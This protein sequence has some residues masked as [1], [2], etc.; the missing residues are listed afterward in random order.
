L[1]TLTSGRPFNITSGS[2]N[3]GDFLFLDRPAAGS[4]GG[5]GVIATRFGTFDVLRSAGEP[6]IRR[7]AGQGPGEFLLNVGIAKRFRMGLAPD[8]GE[9][10]LILSASA[11][12]VTNRINYFEFNGVVTSPLFGIAN[13]ALNPRRVE[14]S[15]RFGF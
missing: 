3:D 6:M 13:R 5:A 2:D 15:A 10:Y 1:L 14:L 12:N 8:G 9:R 4:P 7:N 11:E